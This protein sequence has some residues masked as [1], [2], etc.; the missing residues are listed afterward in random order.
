MWFE[1]LRAEHLVGRPGNRRA[2][3]SWWFQQFLSRLLEAEPAVL[4]LLEGN[5]FPDNPPRLVRAELY[6]YGF[7]TREEKAETGA[8]WSRTHVGR[9]AL[10]HRSDPDGE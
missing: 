5:P 2:E 9:Y 3:P 1:A 6:Q 4:A 8:W 10:M 7:T